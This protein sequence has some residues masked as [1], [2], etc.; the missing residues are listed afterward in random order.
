MCMVLYG[1]CIVVYGLFD[2]A[3]VLVFCFVDGCALCC[4]DVLLYGCVWLCMVV[5]VLLHVFVW[6]RMVCVWLHMFCNCVYDFVTIL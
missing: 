4:I 5:Y 6:V 1:V 2:F 3:F